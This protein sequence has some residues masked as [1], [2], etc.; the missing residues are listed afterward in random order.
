M[1]RR[2]SRRF[3]V[4]VTSGGTRVVIDNL[5]DDGEHASL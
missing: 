4:G 1:S 3:V 2:R 5:G